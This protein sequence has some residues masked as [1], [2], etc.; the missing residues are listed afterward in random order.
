MRQIK[1]IPVIRV[2]EAAIGPDLWAVKGEHFFYRLVV[3]A[4]MDTRCRS[5]VLRD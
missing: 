5:G 1:E 4:I 3:N 2:F